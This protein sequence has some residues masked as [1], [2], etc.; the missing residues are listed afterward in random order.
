MKWPDRMSELLEAG[1]ILE[2]Q[3]IDIDLIKDQSDSNFRELGI[4]MGIGCYLR[5]NIH[6]FKAWYRSN[7]GQMHVSQLQLRTPRPYKPRPDLT[8]P[9]VRNIALNKV[10]QSHTN[11]NQSIETLDL[12][13][14]ENGQEFIE[15]QDLLE[16]D[17]NGLFIDIDNL[18]G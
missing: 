2:H 14:V 9:P 7:E 8:P 12:I 17:D 10:V 4:P 18:V 6:G 5:K 3:C 13:G 1:R 16:L 15:T 11:R